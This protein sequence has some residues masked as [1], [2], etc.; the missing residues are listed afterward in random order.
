M[1]IELIPPHTGQRKSLIILAG[2]DCHLKNALKTQTKQLI[3]KKDTQL[4]PL[5]F[6]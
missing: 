2:L 3:F 4:L 1:L 6:F 5:H